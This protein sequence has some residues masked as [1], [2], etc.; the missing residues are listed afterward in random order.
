MQNSKSTSSAVEPLEDFLTD[1]FH[2]GEAYLRPQWEKI[3]DQIRQSP[4]KAVLIAAGIG[5]CLH[6]LPASSL[7]GST[8]KL[9]WAIAPPAA[10]AALA[11]KGYVLLEDKLHA[12]E[13]SSKSRSS[14]ANQRAT[15]Q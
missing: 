14:R 15:A 1:V 6:R 13:P 7:L 4:T 8:L 12:N 5:Y 2:K 10:M 9:A 3:E 11:G